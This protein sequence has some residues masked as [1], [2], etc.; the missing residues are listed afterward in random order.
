EAAVAVGDAHKGSVIHRRTKPHHP[1]VAGP[2]ARDVKVID[3]GLAKTSFATGMTATGLIMGTPEYMSPEQI[4]GQRSDARA[5]VYA[6]GAVAYYA[7]TGRPPFTGDTPIAV[8]FAR[9]QEPP[10]PPRELRP[11]IPVKLEE[12]I[13]RALAKD[14]IARYTDAGAWK[15]A[16]ESS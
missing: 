16:L 6:L 5:D 4:K 9:L 15:E 14:P 12:V 13:L 1:L 3:F 11:E 10:R 2:H 7:L 8:G